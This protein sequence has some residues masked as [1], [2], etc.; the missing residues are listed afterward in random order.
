MSEIA[1]LGMGNP[2]LDIIADVTPDFLDSYGIKPNNAILAEE[3]HLPIYA[4]MD[5]KFSVTYVAGGATLNAIRVCQALLGRPKGTAYIGCIGKDN[6]GSV[7]KGIA[8]KEGFI[9]LFAESDKN[10]TGSCAVP[11]VSGERSLVA[12]IAAANDYPIDHLKYKVWEQVEKAKICYSASFFLT[13]NPPAML[14]MADHCAKTNKLYCMNLSAP[15]L[16]EFFREPMMQVMP[17]V[18]ILFGNESECA[19]FGKVHGIETTDNV[20]IAKKIAEMPKVNHKRPRM[21]VVTQGSESTI[22]AT[23]WKGAG[24]KVTTYPVEPLERSKLVDTNGAGDAFVGGFLYGLAIDKD[25]DFC[26]F[27]AHYAARHVI[28]RSGCTFDFTDRPD[29]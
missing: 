26:V 15:F 14:A 8:S 6:Y 24:V 4:D 12:N 16:I 7:M 18:D 20:A 13:V 17:Y 19:H 29:H 27:M 3:K 10:P 11:V 21:V 2:L 22:V 25:L 9:P 23:Q 28:Q 5:A 1:V